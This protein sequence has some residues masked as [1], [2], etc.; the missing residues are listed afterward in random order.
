MEAA[1]YKDR[2]KREP[3]IKQKGKDGLHQKNSFK[4]LET[5]VKGRKMVN[6]ET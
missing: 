4:L 5:M 2:D 3:G 6:F 1:G